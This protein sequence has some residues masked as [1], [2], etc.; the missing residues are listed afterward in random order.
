[1]VKKTKNKS[2]ETGKGH[3]KNKVIGTGSIAHHIPTASFFVIQVVI[4]QTVFFWNSLGALS[5]S[6]NSHKLFNMQN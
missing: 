6:G 4:L 2:I 3:K 1:M 5:I